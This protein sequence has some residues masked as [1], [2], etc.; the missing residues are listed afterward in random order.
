MI[1]LTLRNS[2]SKVVTFHLPQCGPHTRNDVE[3]Y[4]RTG[5]K[6]WLVD[7]MVNGK[8]RRK[9]TRATTKTRAMEVAAVLIREAQRGGEPKPKGP[10]PKL[11]VFAEEKFLPFIKS[12]Q[13]D[14]DSKRYYENGWRMLKSTP[15]T[16]QPIASIKAAHAATLEFPGSGSNANCALRTLRRMLSFARDSEY[17]ENVP[18]IPLRKENERSAT[19]SPKMEKALLDVAPQPLRDVFL[20]SQDSGLRPDEVIRMCWDNVLWDKHLIF[21][22]NGKT[23]KSRRHV[24]LSDRVRAALKARAEGSTSPWVFPS[25][26]KKG[27]HI[28]YYT[29]GKGI[30]EVRKKLALPKDLVLYSARHTFATDMLD[31][32]GNL[33][34]VQKMLGH[35]SIL[36][37]QRY[38]HPE[39]KDVAQLVNQRNADNA[40]E[41]LRHSL[42]HSGQNTE[43]N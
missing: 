4:K 34:L 23:V 18:K 37:T 17:I 31:R 29:I 41:N 28:S 43:V 22:P 30:M 33:A 25:S 40:D 3:I 20:I 14:P 32:T 27:T 21:N 2:S 15:I 42:R 13:L 16:D 12:S 36:T 8:R 11:Q 39:L 5:S 9:S 35:E 10:S 6:Y 19:F 24:P 26:R 1:P 7:F 38:L